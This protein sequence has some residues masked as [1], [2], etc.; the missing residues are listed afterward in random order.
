[1]TEPLK[2]NFGAAPWSPAEDA[3]LRSLYGTLPLGQIAARLN[4]SR[5]SVIGRC[6][7]LHLRRITNQQREPTTLTPDVPTKPVTL[8]SLSIL[9][10]RT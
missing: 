4:R 8:P 7:R 1:M 5:N 6:H 3:L 2:P 10:A 9:K